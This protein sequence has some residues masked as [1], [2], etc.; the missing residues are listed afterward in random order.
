MLKQQLPVLVVTEVLVDLVVQSKLVMLLLW[1]V[2]QTLSTVTWYELV[3]VSVMEK[4]VVCEYEPMT[5]P[6][7]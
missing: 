1:P 7:S 4:S 6:H 2:L 5:L 3:T